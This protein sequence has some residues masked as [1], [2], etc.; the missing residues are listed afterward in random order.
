MNNGVTGKPGARIAVEHEHFRDGVRV[1]LW[2]EDS[3]YRCTFEQVPHNEG[4]VV[5]TNDSFL[6]FSNDEA[7][8]LCQA[9]HDSGFKPSNGSGNPAHISALEANLNDLRQVTGLAHQ[10]QQQLF[11]LLGIRPPTNQG[12]ADGEVGPTTPD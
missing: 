8:A 5:P 10:N 9:L 7:Q 1:L 6:R 2:N 11:M 12:E 3:Y 4:V